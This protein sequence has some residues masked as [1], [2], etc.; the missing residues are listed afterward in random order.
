MASQVLTGGRPLQRA[1]NAGEEPQLVDADSDLLVAGQ[2]DRLAGV[3]DLGGDEVLGPRLEG[4]RERQQQLL[5][6]AR[7]DAP[8]RGERLRR[9]RVGGIDVGWARQRS[10]VVGL[11]G[12]R[13]DDVAGAAIDSGD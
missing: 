6:L 3:R 8:P 7:R 13:I 10:G 12:R 4:V 2:G 5:P 11:A 1:G 9:R